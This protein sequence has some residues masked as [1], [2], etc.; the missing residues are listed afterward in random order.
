MEVATA[1][2]IR[3]TFGLPSVKESTLFDQPSSSLK[4]SAGLLQPN[5]MDT[6]QF[7]TMSAQTWSDW[8][9]RRQQDCLQRVS[10]GRAKCESDGSSSLWPTPTT[11]EGGKI[12]CSA[13]YGQKGLSNHPA[14]QGTPQREKRKKS[15]GGLADPTHHSTRGKSQGLL[16]PDWVEQLMGFQ[17]GFTSCELTACDHLEMQ[18]SQ[19]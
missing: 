13:N 15:R 1:S 18:L 19:Q 2:K 16:N 9:T 4:T 5:P 3:D 10:L 8:V 7:S 12:S 14:I 17:P 11:A 6:S